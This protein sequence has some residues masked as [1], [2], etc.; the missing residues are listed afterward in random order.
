[1]RK[2]FIV[3]IFMIMLAV[4]V[5]ACGASNGQGVS[6]GT[7][8]V[9]ES[10][11]GNKE[12]AD[13]SEVS[14]K[15]ESSTASES[16]KKELT[17]EEE[18]VLRC[19][20]TD[21]I[22]KAYQNLDPEPIKPFVEEE[23]YEKI[24]AGMEKIKGDSEKL[25]LWNNTVGT[26]I[27][28]PDSDFL[29]AKSI[30]YTYYAW[31][32]DCWRENKEIPADDSAEFSNEY[33]NEIY[34]NYYKDAPYVGEWNFSKVFKVSITSEG[35]AK[36]YP[37]MNGNNEESEAMVTAVSDKYANMHAEVLLGAEEYFGLGYDYIEEDIPDYEAF[38]SKDLNAIM[39]VVEASDVIDLDNTMS[40]SAHCYKAYYQDEANRA[41]LQQFL[42]DECEMFRSVSS[43]LLVM[44]PNTSKT[45]PF[46]ALTDADRAAMEEM[47]LKLATTSKLIWFNK[48]NFVMLSDLAEVAIDLG[49]IEFVSMF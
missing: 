1:M 45:F 21:I 10:V 7:S 34:N 35:V 40:S 47:D 6:S 38:L 30:E 20:T 5:T 43:I 25:E 28:F 29:L 27:Y 18:K 41:V 16:E 8:E 19:Q 17:E 39:Q 26:M 24:C 42:N 12:S 33:L 11:N 49:L 37:Q 15:G 48:S 4:G 23:T 13:N 46:N 14:E 32:T 2:K 31:Y 9:Q 36:F 44:P 22:L 3:A